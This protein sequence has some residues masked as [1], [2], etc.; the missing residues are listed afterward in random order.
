LLSIPGSITTSPEAPSQ[1]VT[2]GASCCS[3]FRIFLASLSRRLKRALFL[4]QSAFSCAGTPDEY[5]P[6]RVI[7]FVTRVMAVMTT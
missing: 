1:S 4:F 5:T 3:I 7:D 6:G 2:D